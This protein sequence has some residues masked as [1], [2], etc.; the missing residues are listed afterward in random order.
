MPRFSGDRALQLHLHIG[1]RNGSKSI[2][3]NSKNMIQ[4]IGSDYDNWRIRFVVN[5]YLVKADT[6]REVGETKPLCTLRSELCQD[7]SRKQMLSVANRLQKTPLTGGATDLQIKVARA[8]SARFPSGLSCATTAIA[9]ANT[10]NTTRTICLGYMMISMLLT[11]RP[12][13]PLPVRMA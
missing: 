4:K 11:Y 3:D 12:K 5:L 9:K 1:K 6:S 8:V 2:C 13:L 10:A 7:Q